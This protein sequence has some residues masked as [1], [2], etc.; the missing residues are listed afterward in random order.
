ME[1]KI[2]HGSSQAPPPPHQYASV[3]RYKLHDSK[4]TDKTPKSIVEVG[5]GGALATQ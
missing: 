4:R 1:L 2:S 5:G 3:C